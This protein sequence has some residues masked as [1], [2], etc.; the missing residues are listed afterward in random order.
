M[1][2]MHD[3]DTS[4]ACCVEACARVCFDTCQVFCL[5]GKN[6]ASC[7]YICAIALPS[8]HMLQLFTCIQVWPPD[9]MLL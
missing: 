1:A 7:N 8:A 5:F 9:A 6:Y 3:C 4:R 2:V